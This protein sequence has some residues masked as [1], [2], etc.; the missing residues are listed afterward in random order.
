[1]ATVLIS[2][3]GL[4]TQRCF[5]AAAARKSAAQQFLGLLVSPV[6]PKQLRVYIRDGCSGESQAEGESLYLNFIF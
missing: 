6:T 2:L 5:Q 4:R 3:P 1:M